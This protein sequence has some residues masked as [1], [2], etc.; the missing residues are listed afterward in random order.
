MHVNVYGWSEPSIS[1]YDENYSFQTLNTHMLVP[2]AFQ[3]FQL[4]QI[5]ISF[6][7][8]TTIPS[9]L[10]MSIPDRFSAQF[11]N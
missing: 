11:R 3:Q 8:I 4:A 5:T 9:Y 6:L 2:F 7:L 1:L 10:Y